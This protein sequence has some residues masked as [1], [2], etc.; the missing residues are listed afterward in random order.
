MT[1][2]EIKCEI[3]KIL[4]SHNKELQTLL[5]DGYRIEITLILDKTEVKVTQ[6]INTAGRNSGIRIQHDGVSSTFPPIDAL[7]FAIE[8]IGYQRFYDNQG[9]Q[10]VSRDRPNAE[11]DSWVKE[12]RD[13]EG[14]TW[15]V[16]THS[17]TDSKIRLLNNMFE[18]LGMDWRAER[19]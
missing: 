13:N 16:Y 8:R 17:G 3:E 19:S 14:N 12:C 15:F 1:R 4:E 18:R 6:Q 10:I 5:A 7:L 9:T 2:D 11:K